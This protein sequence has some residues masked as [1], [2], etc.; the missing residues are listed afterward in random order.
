VSLF[1]S[2]LVGLTTLSVAHTVACFSSSPHASFHSFCVSVLLLL[3]I[4]FHTSTRR[5]KSFQ[6]KKVTVGAEWW[7]LVG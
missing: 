3:S 6:A 7:G 1:V 4:K 2:W 5:H